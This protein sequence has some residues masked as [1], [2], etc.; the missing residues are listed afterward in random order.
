M[1]LLFIHYIFKTYIGIIQSVF[2]CVNVMRV[3]NTYY[4]PISQ[5]EKKEKEIEIQ[6]TIL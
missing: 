4:M 6:T 2:A 3:I 5:K 1:I